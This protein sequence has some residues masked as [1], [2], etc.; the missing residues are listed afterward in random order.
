[1]RLFVRL[2]FDR[3]PF[4]M[5]AI[6]FINRLGEFAMENV[7]Y[8]GQTETRVS[9]EREP[10]QTIAS[11]YREIEDRLID[12]GKTLLATADQ[13]IWKSTGGVAEDGWPESKVDFEHWVTDGESV[14]FEGQSVELGNGLKIWK[15]YLDGN[16]VYFITWQ[17]GD[18]RDFA[19]EDKLLG[20]TQYIGQE[21]RIILIAFNKDDFECR[22]FSIEGG[23]EIYGYDDY[24]WGDVAKNLLSHEVFAPF[25]GMPETA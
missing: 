16:K 8:Y 4:R 3:L 20:I 2:D 6:G 5:D 17:N 12:A 13:L 19:A 22:A 23:C 10:W 14:E 7:K 18:Y 21:F 1:V 15:S 9:E 24:G 11:E 25:L